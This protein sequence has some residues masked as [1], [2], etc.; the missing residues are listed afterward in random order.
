M[1]DYNLFLE[2]CQKFV[3]LY[4][5]KQFNERLNYMFPNFSN[6]KLKI[7][8]SNFIIVCDSKFITIP[9]DKVKDKG[10]NEIVNSLGIELKNKAFIVGNKVFDSII[11]FK[12]YLCYHIIYV[13]PLIYT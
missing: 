1:D 11:E 6:I 9:K 7:S 4:A 10:N 13:I 2:K 5:F 8:N 12:D 3:N